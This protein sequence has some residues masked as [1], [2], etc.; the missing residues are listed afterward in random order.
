[1]DRDKEIYKTRLT[2]AY[3]I[4]F[5]LV[6]LPMPLAFVL[7][8]LIGSKART[9]TWIEDLLWLFAILLVAVYSFFYLKYKYTQIIL[10][11]NE[12]ELKLRSKKTIILAR[13][14]IANI[15]IAVWYIGIEKKN[16]KKIYIDT[17]TIEN[18]DPNRRSI[19]IALKDWIKT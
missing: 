10:K 9:A 12:L 14:E 13:E 1:M 2:K 11:P 4:L 6:M 3:I 16:G 8:Y 17:R 7:M 5:Y 18:I 19:D 15:A